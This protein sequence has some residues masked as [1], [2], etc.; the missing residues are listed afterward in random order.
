MTSLVLNDCKELLALLCDAPNL[1]SA[2][3]SGSSLSEATFRGGNLSSLKVD[4]CVSLEKI[5]VP[6]NKLT[7]VD[8]SSC[9]ALKRLTINDNADMTELNLS[10]LDKLEY[11]RVGGNIVDAFFDYPS[12]DLRPSKLRVLKANGCTALQEIAGAD[13][14]K[15]PH[16]S[17]YYEHLPSG[18]ETLE[19]NGCAS[20]KSLDLAFTNLKSIDLNG[21][22]AL[23]YVTIDSESGGVLD[24]SACH[25][26]K[27]ISSSGYD[28]VDGT[29]VIM[30]DDYDW[31]KLDYV[32]VSCPITTKDRYPYIIRLF[33]RRQ[34]KNH[35]DGYGRQWYRPDSHG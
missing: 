20:L 32:Y 33:G 2:D 24:L 17:Y 28:C 18:L 31:S 29:A 19:L 21:C 7:S 3:L 22:T 4:G 27:S 30:G 10:G 5:F 15:D 12:D 35:S 11:V 8:L 9:I 1:A 26:I 16:G 14:S 34:R 13:Y 25:N 23:E 6:S